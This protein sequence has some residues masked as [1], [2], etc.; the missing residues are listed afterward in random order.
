MPEFTTPSARW[1]IYNAI[2][3]ALETDEQLQGLKVARNPRTAQHLASGEQLVLIKW[4][5]DSPVETAGRIER[6]KFRLIV[7]AI[8]RS[9]EGA[10]Q[11]A[12]AIHQ[13]AGDVVKRTLPTLH[14]LPGIDRI[15]AITEND[16]TPDVDGIEVD[17]AMVLSSWEIDYQT[18]RAD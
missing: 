14:A 2:A 4:G 8:S 13:A 5:S 9:R 1:K 11:D 3:H 6:R 16:T 7:G 12:D 10:D 18:R 15:K 17:G